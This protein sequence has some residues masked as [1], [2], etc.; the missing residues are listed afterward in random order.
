MDDASN[1]APVLRV[2]LVLPYEPAAF[3]QAD[4]DILSRRF[5]LDK[6]VHNSGKVKLFLRVVRRMLFRKP[7]VLL[8]WFVVPSYALL[9]TLL[10]RVLG[11]KVAFVTG[12]YDIVGMPSIGFGALRKPLFRALLRLTVPLAD[13]FL[14]FSKSASKQLRKS[15]KPRASWV[16]YPGVD[17]SFFKPAPL[18]GGER[19]A[20]ALTVSPV[21]AVSIKQKGL[22]TFVEAARYA[23]DMVWVLVGASPDGS[24]EQL[25]KGAA[26]NVVFMDTFLP[27]EELRDLY[28]RATCYVQVSLHEGF[29]VAVAEAMACGS[30]PVVTRQWS[31]PEVAGSVG[32]YVQ[33]GDA[34]ATAQAALLSLD[35]GDA[36][37]KAA[38]ARIVEHYPVERRARELT[39]ALLSLVPG[40]RQIAPD[41]RDGAPVKIDLGCGSVKKPGFLGIDVR[42]TRATGIVADAQALPVASGSVDAL[43]ATCLLEHFDAPHKVLDEVHR[44]LKPTGVATFRL[45]NLGTYSSHMDTTHRFLADLSIWRQMFEGYFST[46]EVVPVGTKYRESKSLV[47]VNWVLVNVLKWHEL[48]QGWDFLCSNPRPE[49]ILSYVGWWEEGEHGDRIGGQIEPVA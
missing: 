1:S 28:R 25:R 18:Q 26:P 13:M 37:R 17:I 47:A 35:A 45:P 27:Q 39:A 20:L 46:V 9:F 34:K 49:P 14:P 12:G 44:I 8:M 31:L 40:K 42:P 7:D 30:V 33:A 10:A 22:D 41:M 3:M 24:I 32:R 38:R 15:A 2:L 6:I 21:T 43:E 16:V 48:A 11:V 4:I 23:P 29:G 19:E 36:V 5:Q